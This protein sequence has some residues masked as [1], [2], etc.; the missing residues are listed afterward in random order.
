MASLI[1]GGIWDKWASPY[2][3]ICATKRVGISKDG[4]SV[5]DMQQDKFQLAAKL[6]AQNQK[7]GSPDMLVL[8]HKR[9][10]VHIHQWMFHNPLLFQVWHQVGKTETMLLVCRFLE[11][12]VS[13][14]TWNYPKKLWKKLK[15]AK[16]Y[17]VF[18]QLMK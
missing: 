18:L 4:L 15:S 7:Q 12:Y 8:R 6:I 3:I 9:R 2:F 5:N 1:L 10:Y 11:I 17:Q 13:A 14:V 16:K